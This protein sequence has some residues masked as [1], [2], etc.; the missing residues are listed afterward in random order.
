MLGL[1]LDVGFDVWS[2]IV[3]D[4]C[5]R[6]LGTSGYNTVLY[7]AEH[8]ADNCS[9]KRIDKLCEMN[10][11]KVTSEHWVRKQACSENQQQRWLRYQ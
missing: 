11:R 5:A 6:Y 3:T 8:V 9:R 4:V 2:D 7:M 1:G 10:V